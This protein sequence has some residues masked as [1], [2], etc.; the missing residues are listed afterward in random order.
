MNVNNLPVK[1]LE[2]LVLFAYE[3]GDIYDQSRN[4]GLLKHMIEACEAL[5][6]AGSEITF[7]RYPERSLQQQ[8][9]WMKEHL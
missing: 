2:R 6:V 3:S 7:G 4:P 8:I 9:A 5:I 1:A